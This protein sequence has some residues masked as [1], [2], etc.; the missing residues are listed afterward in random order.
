MEY[1]VLCLHGCC[2]SKEIFINL[3]NNFTKI[4]KN[5]KITF[6]FIQGKYEHPSRGYTWYNIPLE[7]DDIG[8]CDYDDDLVYECLNDIEIAIKT[9]NINVLLGF[10]Q[11]GNVVDTFIQHREHSQIKRA[12]IMSSYSLNE[13]T[14][15]TIDDVE[16]LNVISECDEIV[17]H[18]LF[19]K[20]YT[21]SLVIK[22]DKGH[23]IPG[24]PTMRQIRNFILE[25]NI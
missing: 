7:L 18:D 19:P 12:I 24:S 15:K 11:G 13:P 5:D 14:R 17:K 2:Q 25:G 8:I 9:N 20:N 3:L 21:K 1:N 6:Y 23:K 10:S 4:C 22:H 16:I